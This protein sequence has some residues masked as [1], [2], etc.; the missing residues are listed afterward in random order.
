[1]TRG[2]LGE[3][4]ADAL[5]YAVALA[6]R[7]AFSRHNI[8]AALLSHDLILEVQRQKGRGRADTVA[9]GLVDRA[10]ERVQM[11]P[12]D[13]WRFEVPDRIR[14]YRHRADARAWP[15][16]TGR[17]DRRALEAVYLTALLAR[18]TRFHLAASTWGLRAGMPAMA[19]SRASRRLRRQG[20]LRIG[21]PH[22]ATIAALYRIRSPRS[23]TRGLPPRE[24]PLSRLVDVALLGVSLVD[25][26]GFERRLLMHDGFRTAALG[27]DGWAVARWLSDELPIEAQRLA[28]STGVPPRRVGHVLE[29]LEAH[30]AAS[31]SD[32]GWR[33]ALEP[34]FFEAVGRIA[35]DAGT[36]GSLERDRDTYAKERARRDTKLAESSR[37]LV[38]TLPPVASWWS[39]WGLLGERVSPHVA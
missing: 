2:D 15:G 28:R 36:L 34:F 35:I 10:V 18:S 33:R 38:V 8:Y 21:R 3:H 4:Y 22:T 16:R 31:Q 9:R 1:M 39:R 23:V 27:D 7:P 19:V 26:L 30:G 25:E 5:S 24:V 32:D 13:L 12:P 17:A 29:V 11:H 14:R 6:N 20:Y 37:S